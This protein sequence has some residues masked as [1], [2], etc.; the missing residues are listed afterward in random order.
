MGE[1][2]PSQA[3]SISPAIAPTGTSYGFAI[4]ALTIP[5]EYTVTRVSFLADGKTLVCR[6]SLVKTEDGW[7]GTR[8]YAVSVMFVLETFMK[9]H[10]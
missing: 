4:G 2:S 7:L 10:T 3:L 5:G 1:I 9:R 6:N 8:D